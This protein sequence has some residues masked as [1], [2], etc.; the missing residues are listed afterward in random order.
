MHKYVIAFCFGMELMASRT[1]TLIFFIYIAV[2][3]FFST[4][5]IGIGTAISESLTSSPGYHITIGVL[6]GTLD[7]YKTFLF[8]FIAII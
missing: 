5:G 3:S 8:V 6:Q 4:L 1:R 2:F 7:N